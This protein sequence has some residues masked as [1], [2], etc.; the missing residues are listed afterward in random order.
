MTLEEE[1]V[2]L[3]AEVQELREELAAA[4]ERIAELERGRKG[5]P[6]FVKA[7]R[8]QDAQEQKPRRKRAAE[9]NGSRKRE[10]PTRVVRHALKRCP[11]CGYKLQGQSIGRRRQVIELPPPQ[12]VQVTE[13]Q[14]IK[15][16]CPHC[17][18]WQ[19]PK[20]DLRGQ[21]VAY[22]ATWVKGG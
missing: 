21:A 10:K 7:N 11:D 2:F 3:R 19:S 8:P 17:E 9:Q 6:S 1:V 16:W 12:A 14:V 5:P 20:L 13:Y 22:V 18:R 15:R 4:Q